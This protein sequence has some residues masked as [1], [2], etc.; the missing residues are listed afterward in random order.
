MFVQARTH[1]VHHRHTPPPWCAADA[2]PPHR[3]T[4][5]VCRSHTMQCTCAKHPTANANRT[6]ARLRGVVLLVHGP[7][8]VDGAAGRQHQPRRAARVLLHKLGH[9]VHPVLVR[10][11][12]ACSS[13]S[14]AGGTSADWMVGWCAG[15]Q[16]QH[17]CAA[18][19]RLREAAAGRLQDEWV[20]TCSGLIAQS[21]QPP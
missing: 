19:H 13:D 16:G 21:H 14:A 4:S 18:P 7:E 5:W 17:T 20:D 10:H 1:S 12:D 15:R 2:L 11:P 8:G 6:E 9:V 3:K